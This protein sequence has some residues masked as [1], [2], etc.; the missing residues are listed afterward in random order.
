MHLQTA[1]GR[2]STYRLLHHDLV[3]LDTQL[4]VFE[5][6]HKGKRV[7][8]QHVPALG[9]LAQHAYLAACQ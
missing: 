8:I 5:V 6:V 9:L 4:G 2:S 3:D 7:V 1:A